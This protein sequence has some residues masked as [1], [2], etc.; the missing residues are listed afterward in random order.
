MLRLAACLAIGGAAAA[1]CAV[2]ERVSSHAA[3]IVDGVRERGEDAVVM[4]KLG[5]GF[6]SCTGSLIS[7]SVVLTAKHCV[8]GERMDR[9]HPFSI[10]SVGVGHDQRTTQDYRVRRVDTVPGA[11]RGGST[12]AGLRGFDV[13]TI[14]I[15]P[16][17]DGNFPDVEPLAVYRDDPSS[18]VGDE[19]TF[20]GFGR[21]P[22]G[23]GGLKYSTTGEITR[24]DSSVIYSRQNTCSGDSGG[25]MILEGEPRQIVGVASFGTGVDSVTCPS[26]EDGH[27]RLDDYLGIIDAALFE[28]G[29]CPGA[30]DEVC[31]SLDND[32]DGSIDETCKSL[33]EACEADNEC[34][35][36]QLPEAI[37]AGLVEPLDNP[38]V[39]ADSPDGRV[40]THACNPLDPIASC[41]DVPH[42]LRARERIAT[43]GAV[44]VPVDSGCEGVCVAG[45]RGNTPIGEECEANTDCASARCLDPGDG[46]RRCLTSC[47]G[48]AGTCPFD[49][50]C[51]AGAGSCGGCVSPELLDEPRGLGESCAD[52]G[53]CRSNLCGVDGY[54]TIDCERSMDC[55]DSFHCR[56]GQCARGAPGDPGDLCRDEEDCAI[57]AMCTTSGD[58]STCTEPCTAIGCEEGF[59]C[60]D[61][62]CVVDL[63][64]LGDECDAGQD[65]FSGRCED[66]DGVDRCTQSCEGT[67]SCPTTLFCRRSQRGEP[68][69][70]TEPPP[71]PADEEDGGGCNVGSPPQSTWP[72]FILLFFGRRSRARSTRRPAWLH[73]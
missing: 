17:A 65:C 15:R 8:Q 61:E 3:P 22:D 24:I 16:D 72:L 50:V 60:E 23:P 14:T 18:L 19:V 10:V 64:V 2:H 52:D 66:V 73:R 51:A 11:Y 6:T 55:R 59:R 36:A 67:G 58:A 71:E 33:G 28:A 44:C 62:R 43:P 7:P 26:L 20:V 54:C 69:C 42:A 34:A 56:R 32:C 12:L 35:H 47:Q 45:E 46:R 1:G 27:N 21:R 63:G 48:D 57:G 68:I 53:E 5:G 4:I 29:D 31:D 39:C 9:P 40:C 13:A 30:Q 41:A 38:V 49:E 70:A 25:P 37:T